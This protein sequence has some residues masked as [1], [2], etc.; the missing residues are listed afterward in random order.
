MVQQRAGLA[1]KSWQGRDTVCRAVIYLVVQL[2]H[3]YRPYL[4]SCLEHWGLYG[5]WKTKFDV[6]FFFN[7][8]VYPNI[9]TGCEG[10]M[11]TF[12]SNRNI[13]QIKR[14][15]DELQIEMSS[16]W[17][18]TTPSHMKVQIS[19]R[20]RCRGVNSSSGRVFFVAVKSVGDCRTLCSVFISVG[21]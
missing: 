20:R 4:L 2:E 9:A 16:A 14:M 11:M 13:L 21:A 15:L 19:F 12:C 7:L 6:Q 5:S 17:F 1:S 3:R 18:G 10:Q 8:F